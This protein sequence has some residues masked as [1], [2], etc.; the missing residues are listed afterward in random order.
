MQ[1]GLYNKNIRDELL[2]LV[3]IVSLVYLFKAGRLPA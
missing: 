3:L 1:K 2:S